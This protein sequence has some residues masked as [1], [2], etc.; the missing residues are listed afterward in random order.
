MKKLFGLLAA[1]VAFN[2]ASAFACEKEEVVKE[3]TTQEVVVQETSA[4]EVAE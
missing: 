2:A 1:V 3:E 4:A